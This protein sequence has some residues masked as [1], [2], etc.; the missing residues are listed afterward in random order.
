MHPLAAWLKRHGKR[1]SAFAAE[2]A[3]T[4]A[5]I[6]RIC[7]GTRPKPDLSLRIVGATQNEVSLDDLMRRQPEVPELP[8]GGSCLADSPGTADEAAE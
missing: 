6:T 5:T 2:V 4:P 8:T 1:R 7:S 3:T